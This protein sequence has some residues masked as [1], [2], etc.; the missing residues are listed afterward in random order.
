MVAFRVKSRVAQCI[1][2]PPESALARLPTTA[3][4]SPNSI[5]VRS[6][7]YRALS[8]PA[9]PGFLLRLIAKTVRALSASIIGMP[10]MGLYLSLRAAGFTTSLAPITRATSHWGISGL[11]SSISI[12]SVY[13]ISAS[14]KSTFM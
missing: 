11:I 10:K 7:K 2:E 3:F 13:G 9:K 14:A 4:A 6:A 5:Q 12:R 1:P 8:M